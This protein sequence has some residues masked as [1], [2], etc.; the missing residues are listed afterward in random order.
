MSAE[1]GRSI[2]ELAMA[3]LNGKYRFRGIVNKFGRE[4]AKRA[5]NN[6]AGMILICD[7]DHRK[8]QRWA[9][10]QQNQ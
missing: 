6:L 8:A 1:P 7:P 3:F 4:E 5:I 10:A 9:K 2:D